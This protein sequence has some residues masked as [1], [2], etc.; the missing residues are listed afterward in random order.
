MLVVNQLVGSSTLWAQVEWRTRMSANIRNLETLHK[1]LYRLFTVP[2]W[3][4]LI[5]HVYT[6]Y[7]THNW[8]VATCC[9]LYLLR[10]HFLQGV[11]YSLGVETE[12]HI[13]FRFQKQIINSGLKLDFS[14]FRRPRIAI[15]VPRVAIPAPVMACCPSG[16]ADTHGPWEWRPRG[17]KQNIGMTYQGRFISF[18]CLLLGLRIQ[19]NFQCWFD[20]K[21]SVLILIC[22]V[23]PAS[24]DFQEP[25]RH[26]LPLQT[27]MI[28][29]TALVFL[30]C[31]GK[32]KL[33]DQ[34]Q[35]NHFRFWDTFHKLASKHHS[36]W[37]KRSLWLIE[38]EIPAIG[39]GESK[40]GMLLRT[41]LEL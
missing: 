28:N 17:E 9:N 31:T 16:H 36:T 7:L 12:H 5:P 4:Q 6:Y 39:M 27:F 29:T 41:L 30:C 10:E 20:N 2:A 38:I 34:G 19:C 35:L 25:F 15:P 26:H 23:Y 37:S 18:Y 32:H 13:R 22:F 21:H 1:L 24:C 11:P 3:S 14:L 33:T 40:C 8:N